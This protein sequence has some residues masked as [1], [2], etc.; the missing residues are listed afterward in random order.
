MNRL[1]GSVFY[2]HRI[3]RCYLKSQRKLLKVFIKHTSRG[4]IK[5]LIIIART[6]NYYSNIIGQPP[7]TGIDRFYNITVKTPEKI[8][9]QTISR[10][11]HCRNI[12][13]AKM[14]DESPRES[15][16]PSRHGWRTDFTN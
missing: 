9:A 8:T 10:Q 2:R 11:K 4:E 3:L 12:K 1:C 15:T 7:S 14:A 13:N 16:V 6:V 5:A